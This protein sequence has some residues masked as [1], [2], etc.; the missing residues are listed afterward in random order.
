VEKSKR[1]PRLLIN[2]HV[3]RTSA[4][5]HQTLSTSCS[6]P[7]IPSRQAKSKHL[8]G[9]DQRLSHTGN[10][11]VDTVQGLFWKPISQFILLLKIPVL[12][13]TI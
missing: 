3:G 4:K 12:V 2:R 5:L 9:T 10:A 6:A 1:S 8:R 13:F 11:Q 7:D